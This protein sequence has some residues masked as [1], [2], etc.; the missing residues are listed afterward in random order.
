MENLEK[1]GIVNYLVRYRCVKFT[2]DLYRDPAKL[3]ADQIQEWLSDLRDLDPGVEGPIKSPTQ[4]PDGPPI[5]A[6]LFSYGDPDNPLVAWQHFSVAQDDSE[7]LLTWKPQRVDDHIV[8]LE[9]V[10]PLP[11]QHLPPQKNIDEG[12]ECHNCRHFSH[13]QGQEW[14]NEI[15]HRFDK[16]DDRMWRDVLKMTTSKFDV[17]IPDSD[18]NFGA[19]LKNKRLVQADFPGCEHYTPK[20]QW[21]QST[22]SAQPIE[23]AQEKA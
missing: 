19:C 2:E 17:E 15:T 12:Y 6:K 7:H 11:I 20:K 18:K 4:H 22:Q 23:P 10:P 5:V 16:A 8:W 9:E 13:E 21:K 3:T 1:W 14:L